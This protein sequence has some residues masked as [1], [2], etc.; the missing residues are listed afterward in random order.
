MTGHRSALLACSILACSLPAFSAQQVPVETG[1][2]EDF[3]LSRII[4]VY[5]DPAAPGAGVVDALARLGHPAD[6][7]Q[8]GG[9]PGWA[10]VVLDRDPRSEL[11]RLSRSGT[12]DMV[13]PI[14]PE[15]G[16]LPRF[17]TRDLLVQFEVDGAPVMLGDE[18][19]I[20][21]RDFAGTPG[22]TRVRTG[23]RTGAEAKAI[24]A[25]IAAR[26]GVEFAHPDSIYWARRHGGGYVPNDPQFSSQWGLDQANDHDMNAPEA[27]MMTTGDPAI[28]VVVFDSGIQAGH[29]DLSLVPGQDFTGGNSDGS[30]NSTCDN[31][32]TAVAGCVAATIDNGI[33]IVGIAPDCR[34]KS[35]KIFNEIFFIAFCL[36]FLESQDSWTVAGINWAADSG[37]RVTNSSWG[38]GTGSAAVSGAFAST[39]EA[40]VLHFASTGNDGTSTIGFPANLPSINAVSAIQSSGAIASFSTIGNG[41]F[42]CAPG[43]S[44]LT[45]DRTGGDGYGSGDTTSIDGTSF[46]SPYAAGV[47]ALV[48]A[49]DPSLTPEEVEQVLADT[50]KD[51]GAAGYDTTF[52][53]GLV[54]A[55]AAVAAVWNDEEP[56]FGDLNG[57][58]S[59]NGGD[60][61]FVIADWGACPGCLGDLDGDGLVTGADL[62]LMISAFGPCP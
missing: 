41:N 11:A 12:I 10:Y 17:P 60:L 19:E 25:G 45:T 14:L 4:A 53:W 22:L 62:G 29:P 50:A 21:D 2:V 30:P 39:R 49:A 36:P 23:A 3:D 5:R 57:D 55:A 37:A 32:G 51:R 52:G 33:G 9:V 1:V 35:G 13:T 16:N 20:L 47:A 59:V 15:D 8:P 6:R 18:F 38:G 26:P 28:E 40:G 46:S 27:W 24:A 31:H 42:I 58:G 48:L 43:V 44:I 7:V 56:C 34:V 61:G 54:D